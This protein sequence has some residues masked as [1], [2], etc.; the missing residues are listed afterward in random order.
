MIAIPDS[1][2][3]LVMCTIIRTQ[4]QHWTD[5]WT[6][7]VKLYRGLHAMHADVQKLLNRTYSIVYILHNNTG[8]QYSEHSL[9]VI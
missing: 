4:H 5:G 9:V 6:E 7:M 1:G 3:S 2:K 8:Y